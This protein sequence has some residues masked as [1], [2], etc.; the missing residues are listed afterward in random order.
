VFGVALDEVSADQ[1]RSAKA[2]NFGLMYGMSAWGLA[3]Q[4]ETGRDVA[5][6]YIERYFERYPGVRRYMDETRA[7]ARRQGFVETLAGRRLWLPEINS[8]NRQR[9]QAAERAAINAPLQGTAAD[10]IKRAMIDVDGWIQAE[11][12]PANLVMQVHDELVLEVKKDALEEVRK[13]VIE[14][15]SKA[16]ELDVELLV[17]VGDGQDWDEAH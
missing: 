6:E 16:G 1:R 14:R 9:Q 12:V 10:I 11:N 15:M 7:T 5:A 4:L 8:R 13:G 2:I 17:D 3:R